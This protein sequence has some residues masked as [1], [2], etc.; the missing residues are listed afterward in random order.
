MNKF[1]KIYTHTYVW[2]ICIYITYI[3]IFHTESD[4]KITKIQEYSTHSC[5]QDFIPSCLVKWSLFPSHNYVHVYHLLGG[6][7]AWWA[8]TFFLT[9]L[10][11]FLPSPAP[12][13]AVCWSRHNQDRNFQSRENLN[14]AWQVGK[15][16]KNI[17]KSGERNSVPFFCLLVCFFSPQAGR[18]P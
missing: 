10:S 7:Q 16:C 3:L 18:L 5:S 12:Q 1:W 13:I 15:I 4:A 11:S 14:A 9:I 8:G 17:I 6:E 2:D